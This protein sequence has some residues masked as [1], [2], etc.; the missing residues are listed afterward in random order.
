MDAITSS[1]KF[2]PGRSLTQKEIHKILFDMTNLQGIKSLNVEPEMVK[3]EFFQ[4]FL[5]TDI[6][7]D[8]LVKAGFP[9]I[10]NKEEKPGIFR[11]F[12]RQLAQDN[13]TEFGGKPPKCC[14]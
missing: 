5:S 11:K 13:K 14:G 7:K 1:I 12:I 2:I 10:T 4:Q 9:F 6:I 3:V 8:S